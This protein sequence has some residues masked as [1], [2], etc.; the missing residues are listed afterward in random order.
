[1]TDPIKQAGAVA[2]F[3]LSAAH[4]AADEAG[5]PPDSPKWEKFIE[6]EMKQA[7]EHEAAAIKFRKLWDKAKPA[8][9]DHP[10]LKHKGVLDASGLR[11]SGTKLL[12]P[13]KGIEPGDPIMN[14]QT[15]EPNGF[16]LYG[17][18]GRTKNTRTTI[19][20]GRFKPTGTMYIAEG[21]ATGWS[22]HHASGCPVVVAF[23]AEGLTH[24]AV[25]MRAR[26]PKAD[27]I[28]ASD[29]DRWSKMGD[30]QNPGLHFAWRAADAI[31]GKVVLPDFTDLTSKPTD[32]N[33]LMALEGVGA[34]KARLVPIQRDAPE[35]D[36]APEPA[37]QPAEPDKKPDIAP[38]PEQGRPEVEPAGEDA[39]PAA[40]PRGTW[41]E[42][43][44]FRCLG[45]D[46]G[47]YFYLPRGTGQI[48]EL[49]PAGHDRKSLMPLAPLSWWERHFPGAKG[50]NWSVAA[51][52]LIQASHRAGVFR[53]ER[54]RGRGCWPEVQEDGSI[55]IVLHLGDRLL[56]PGAK[57]Y[58]DPESYR[59]P[60]NRIYER[61]LRLEGPSRNRALGLEGAQTVLGLFRDL[62]WHE[63]ASGMLLAGW[64]VLGPVCGALPWRPHVWVTGGAGAG[65]TW[66][67]SNLVRPLLGGMRFYYEGGSTEAGIRHE[68]RAD[69]LPVL[70]D[71]AEKGKDTKS[72]ARISG[73]VE[74]IRSASSSAQ[75]AHTAKG[76]SFGGVMSFQ[77]RSMF[78]LASIG[79]TVRNEQDRT[80]ISLLQLRAKEAVPAR[81]RQAHWADYRPRQ[82]FV[83]EERGR[84]LVA[85][86]LGWLRDGRLADCL[87]TMTTQAAVVLGDQRSADQYGTL[88]AGT[89]VLMSDAPPSADEGRELVASVGLKEYLHEQVPEGRRILRTI[90]QSEARIDTPHGPK[91]AAVGE[92]VDVA[93]GVMN[94]LD[95]EA[96]NQWLNRAG[97]RVM[98]N[99]GETVLAFA[100][101][102]DWIPKALSNTQYSD[103]WKD[104]LR[105]LSGVGAG[106]MVRFHG[107]LTSR[108]TIVPRSALET[109]EDE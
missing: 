90:M 67:V 17:E 7:R 88:L 30:V 53:Q 99:N 69:A 105:T 77:I 48:T 38:P 62:L 26:Y 59:D 85:R 98:V 50:A 46:R 52:A 44:R 63:E 58:M 27:I 21:W 40:A 33:D 8:T 15:I 2:Q 83:T 72:D 96:A 81:E 5:I 97:I 43:A 42:D 87:N 79:A 70:Y 11:Q 108:T 34:V 82:G 10:Y 22:V 16:K 95:T 23:N 4:A 12:V 13:M 106:P 89:W 35:P 100:N 93:S 39:P 86:T 24:I 31:G 75:G 109:R 19:G 32:F 47:S 36:P 102:S 65:K 80:R 28:I 66:L 91:T 60:Q 20:K 71:E 101:T 49:T 104:S 94:G 55:Q 61:L 3:R 76:T 103:S 37:P 57:T 29:N 73:V 25:A 9:P 74:L 18:N 92:L 56:A 45:Y 78:C 6:R 84:E 54:L 1:M 51:D 68:V 64:T 107:G 14:I 41:V